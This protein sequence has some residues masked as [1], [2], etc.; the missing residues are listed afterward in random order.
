[1]KKILIGAVVLFVFVAGCNSFRFAPT[2]EQKQNAYL[3]NR[4]AAIAAD[5]AKAENCSQ[6]LQALTN[7]SEVQSR[8]FM[9]YNGLPA[10]YPKAETAEDVLSET[11]AAIT[12]TATLQSADRPDVWKL[13]DSAFE[14]AIAVCGLAG[15]IYGTKA[16]SFLKQAQ[17]K[18]QAL[19]EIVQGNELFKKTNAASV[20]A[21]KAA[22][23]NQSSETRQ[24]VTAMKS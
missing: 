4:T 15:G 1:M 14:L 5:T 20:E 6:E 10:Q 11:S 19:K 2:E 22:Q 24:I 13:T 16:T 18:S 17:A 9:A 8:A 21:F 3:H 12:E 7:L 23:Q